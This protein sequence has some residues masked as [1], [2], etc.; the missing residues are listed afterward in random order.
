MR[1]RELIT[2][3]GKGRSPDPSLRQA[4]LA[5]LGLRALR[6]T[7]LA[8]VFEDAAEV[9]ARSLEVDLTA[10]MLLTPGT[11]ELL[12]TAG[13]GWQTGS[14]GQAHMAKDPTVLSR[15]TL[16]HTEPVAF[17]DLDADVRFVAGPLVRD[18][19]VVSG[20]T[21]PIRGSEQPLGV[22]GAFS[23]QRR[24]FTS[25]ELTFLHAVANTIAIAI[26]RS[27]AV[28]G[29]RATD[30]RLREIVDSA[31]TGIVSVDAN[32]IIVMANAHAGWLFGYGE[33]GL[34]GVDVESVLPGG[35][36]EGR[37]ELRGSS[38]TVPDTQMEAGRARVGLRK[39]GSSFSVEIGVSAIEMPE[40]LL[41]TA[42]V[43]D[44]TERARAAEQLR[45]AVRRLADLNAIDRAIL[46]SESPVD[47]LQGAVERLLD[48][49]G[50]DAAAVTRI[51][52]DRLEGVIDTSV[53]AS[54]S[55]LP[56]GTKI[57][58][59]SQTSIDTLRAGAA[60]RYPNLMEIAEPSSGARVSREAG[61]RS[62]IALPLVIEDRVLGT[63]SVAWYEPD[64]FTE[65]DVDTLREV[66]DQLAVAIRQSQ[67]REEL[68]RHAEQ[69]ELR[70]AER[71]G[72][73]GVANSSLQET[74]AELD[75]FAYSV[76]HDLRAPLRAMQGFAQALREDYGDVLD[77]TGSDY[78]DRIV[79]AAVRMDGL[80]QDLL[81]Y[82]RL[83]REEMKL[84]RVELAPVIDEA[85]SLLRSDI[86]ARGAQITV[87]RALPA[88][89]GHASTLVH[90]LQNLIGNA[91][92]F[93][94]ADRRPEIGI[95]AVVTDG[96]VRISVQDNGIGISPE[97]YE[98]VFGML[99]RLHGQDAFPG[100]GIGLAIVRKGA[101]RMRG[102]VRVGS[103]PLGGSVFTVELPEAP[104]RGAR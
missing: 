81:M 19:G 57:T 62:L 56:K 42:V 84:S 88:V 40:G 47:L 15:Y 27:R 97:H 49:V 6:E 66:A 69:L 63:L 59:I 85:L 93:V 50:A 99:E 73:L 52:Q 8:P 71:T 58:D 67:M 89:I 39:D 60:V 76:A 51:D 18:H 103:G 14:V 95:A 2:S 91:I 37:D 83:S 20:M 7:D 74:N 29:Q 28:E 1:T 55:L 87:A 32:G 78:A 45:K 82:S 43:A 101:E 38:I 100:T 94:E 34:I 9:V 31:P 11:D 104:E 46:A 44:I 16:A 61:L 30:L 79:R 70:V 26:Q 24:S 72:E 96:V 4:A 33:G 65:D 22:L 36:Q 25:E 10:V 92:K 13:V 77:A 98:R 35:L 90:V 64:A 17:E 53:G 102:N 3:E 54:M 21:A 48:L 23:T 86:E 5:D 68:E 41:T 80:I 75:A 12:L